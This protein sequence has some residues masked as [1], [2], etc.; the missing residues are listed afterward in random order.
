ML[1]GYY[2]LYLFCLAIVIVS[3]VLNK[4]I[5]V[6]VISLLCLIFHIKLRNKKNSINKRHK[7][8]LQNM[9]DLFLEYD[10]LLDWE[11][12]ELNKY[13]NKYLTYYVV[14]LN[15][16]NKQLNLKFEKDEEYH[17]YFIWE[18]LNKKTRKTIYKVNKLIF[19]L[20]EHELL[21]TLNVFTYFI[22]VIANNKI[23]KCCD[24][25][26]NNLKILNE[27]EI[28]F[29]YKIYIQEQR[30]SY[31]KSYNYNS[32]KNSNVNNN[33]T[34]DLKEKYLKSFGLTKNNFNETTLKKQY[35]KLCKKYHPDNNTNSNAQQQF[36]EV[37]KR[38]Q[39]LLKHL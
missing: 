7:V 19:F 30:N 12:Q 39:Y 5:V 2:L 20:K 21:I 26:E 22:L 16:L 32:N 23:N 18:N 31:K 35:R 28:F 34:I 4:W 14:Y 24:K 1:I 11:N 8:L 9:F 36:E 3:V 13:Y 29:K 17:N 38:Y 6:G 25:L 15:S 33:K 37:Q 27:I 10:R